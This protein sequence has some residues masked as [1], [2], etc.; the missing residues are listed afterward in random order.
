[1]KS[2]TYRLPDQSYEV[3]RELGPR[4]LDQVP[5]QELAALMLLTATRLGWS[6]EDA[7]FRSILDQ[8]GLRRLTANVTLQLRRVRPI[9]EKSTG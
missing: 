4:P 9:A 6:D 1:M 8:Y 5:P 7:L 3:V 2:L